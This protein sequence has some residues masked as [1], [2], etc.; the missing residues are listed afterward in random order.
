METSPLGASLAAEPAGRISRL[1]HVA[2]GSFW[3]GNNFITTP[4][5]TILLQIQVAEVIAKD[6]QGFAIGL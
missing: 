1:R 3:F 4:V 5:Y 2:L 6:R